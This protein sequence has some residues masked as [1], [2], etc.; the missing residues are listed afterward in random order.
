MLPCNMGRHWLVQAS[1]WL[2]KDLRNT[3]L[4]QGS[5]TTLLLTQDMSLRNWDFSFFPSLIQWVLVADCND[6][7]IKLKGISWFCHLHAPI[8][9]NGQ[10]KKIYSILMSCIYIRFTFHYIYILSL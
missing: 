4:F 2:V 7:C 9:T 6:L 1:S 3:S 5:S 8:L 10:L